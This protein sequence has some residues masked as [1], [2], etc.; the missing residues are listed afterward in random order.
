MSWED[1][2]D[3]Y[4]Y[5]EQKKTGAKLAIPVGL[6]IEELGISLQGVLQKCRKLSAGKAI[7]SSSSGKCL[8]PTTVS[9]AFRRARELCGI[10]FTG[11]PPSFHELRSL[12]ARLYSKQVD[13]SF[14]QHLLGHK[15][16]SMTATYRD[17]RGREWDKIEIK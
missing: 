17:D 8:S 3:G 5:V 11:G 15:S 12:S 2:R 16:G 7:I 10:N 14:A 1:I 4:L 13:D 9:N 6:K